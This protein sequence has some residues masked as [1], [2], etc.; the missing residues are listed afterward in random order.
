MLSYFLLLLI[1]FPLVSSD[2]DIIGK[3]TV[4]YQGW[5][6]APED[7][8]YLKLWWHWS[9]DYLYPPGPSNRRIVS[10]P[11]M[12]E[13]TTSFQ[14]NFSNLG[15]GQP[16]KLFSSFNEQTVSTHFKWM[17]QYGIDVVALQRFNQS[18]YEVNIRNAMAEK[19]RANAEKYGVKFYIMYDVS[20]WWNFTTEIQADWMNTMQAYTNSPA[21]ARQNGKPV[22]CIWGFGFNDPQRPFTPDECLK[23]LNWFKSQGLYVIGGIP[24][25]WRT[26]EHDS[27]PN[28]LP[29]YTAFHMISPWMVG[30]IHNVSDADRYYNIVA[31]QD[32][33][34]L[35]ARGIDYQPCVLPG[36]LSHHDRAHGDFMWR[37][38]Y[39][40]KKLGVQ[41]IYISMFDEFNEGNQIAKTSENAKMTPTGNYTFV[42]L[43]ED[44]VVCS[45]DYYLRLT[46]DGGKM[47]KGEIPLTPIRPTN[48]TCPLYFS[49]SKV[50]NRS[51]LAFVNGTADWNTAN[52]QCGQLAPGATLGSIDSAFE[53]GE[54]QGIINGCNNAYIG[55]HN[56]N[57]NWIW[58]NGDAS[59]YRNWASGY[60]TTN[61][62]SACV[63]MSTSDGKWMNQDCANSSYY[64]CQT[65]V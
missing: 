18:Y 22:I 14:T 33:E 1:N 5:F 7:G 24:T 15:N 56:V 50:N 58:V 36:N 41:A 10:W 54:I 8:S 59:V 32:L 26:G 61:A 45:S 11:D 3:I 44:D 23:V 51:C 25:Y 19:V 49:Q 21:Y 34:Y 9:M 40:M 30:R 35:Q 57:G 28:F 53:N 6:G 62:N 65:V 12:R 64:V 2:G 52:A 38:F 60:P 29:V 42:T 48:P 43:D 16:A 4:G 17:Q 47:F 37:Q 20:D 63:V 39:N 27:R 31:T 55:L 13:Y 46:T